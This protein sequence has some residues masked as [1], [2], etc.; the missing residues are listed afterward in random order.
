M[1]EKRKVNS[2]NRYIR[3]I[4][5]PLLFLLLLVVIV[6]TKAKPFNNE[7]RFEKVA[8]VKEVAFENEN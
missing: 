2:T 5:F 1:P 8:D 7:Y 4:I 3:P 6:A